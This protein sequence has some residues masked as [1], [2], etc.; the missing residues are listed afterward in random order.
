MVSFQI[1]QTSQRP[2]QNKKEQP[3]RTKRTCWFSIDNSREKVVKVSQL[4]RHHH[5]TRVFPRFIKHF[6]PSDHHK[7]DQS[8]AKW[9]CM[10][11]RA[12][13]AVM[14][15]STEVD[16][17]QQIQLVALEAKLGYEIGEWTPWAADWGWWILVL[18]GVWCGDLI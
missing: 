12:S 1:D 6:S 7:V 4:A 14:Y 13:P 16:S 3:A 2:R 15:Q 17:R 18:V 11:Y 10:S 8:G 5:D 9:L